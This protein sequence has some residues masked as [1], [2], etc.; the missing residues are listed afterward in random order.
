MASGLGNNFDLL[1]ASVAAIAVPMAS[2]ITW[3]SMRQKNTAE[4][5]TSYAQAAHVSVETMLQ[6]LD[7]LR[8]EVDQLTAENAKLRADT[9]ILHGE[10]EK[11]RD[12]IRKMGGD[13]M[14]GRRA[15]DP[16]LENFPEGGGVA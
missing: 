7:Q 15:A 6:V 11:L 14:L 3:L 4:A 1:V 8:D 10:V 2:F 16:F 12:V 9:L 5:H 13:P